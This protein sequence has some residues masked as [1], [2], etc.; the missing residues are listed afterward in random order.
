MKAIIQNEYG[1]ES[2]L[3]VIEVEKP[4]IDANQVLIKI[5]SSNIASGDMRINTLDV[6]SFFK[7]IMKII[8]GFK[9]PRNKI[10]GITAAGQIIE[11]GAKVKSYNIGD[12]VNFI[13]SMKAGCLAEYIAMPEKAVM[14]KFDDSLSYEEAA[15]IAFGAMSALRFI[16]KK[17]IKQNSNV[18]I[19]GASG[20]V[21]TYS[22][23]LAKHFGAK[24]TAV[25]SGRNK[26]VVQSIGADKV[27]D[28]EKDDI[29]DSKVKY[30]L[31]FDA[32]MKF[33]KKKAKALLKKDGKYLSIIMPTSEEKSKIELLNNL[34]LQKK[35]T[36]VIDKVFSFN[37]YKA[38]HKLVYSKHKTGNVIININ[39]KN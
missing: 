37:D 7:L 39:E 33:P 5:Y 2:K 14:A 26:D 9:G 10:R 17:T 32:V 16:N 3:K 13:S 24:V 18:L 11:V 36:T 15:P 1:D 12:K 22:V 4:I 29:L 38:A 21:G 19:Y 35:I 34:L 28:Y 27:I 31:I 6:P 23:C 20:S 25:C 30:D 8:F